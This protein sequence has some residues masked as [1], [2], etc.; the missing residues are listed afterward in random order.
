MTVG[1]TTGIPRVEN[2]T[3]KAS[4]T[5]SAL[6]FDVIKDQLPAYAENR[7]ATSS[8]NPERTRMMPARGSSTGALG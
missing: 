2:R 1:S 4:F 6:A 7:L 8:L 3:T 5:G